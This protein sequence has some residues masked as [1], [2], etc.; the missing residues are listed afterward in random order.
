MSPGNTGKSG[1]WF[2]DPDKFKVFRRMFSVARAHV[3]INVTLPSF[4]RLRV[5]GDLLVEVTDSCG[6]EWEPSRG[7]CVLVV[8]TCRAMC[9]HISFR[10]PVSFVLISIRMIGFPGVCIGVSNS[11]ALISPFVGAWCG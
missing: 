2:P 7:V 8:M 1:L 4:G 11:G 9:P 3:N 5:A 10:S 6:S